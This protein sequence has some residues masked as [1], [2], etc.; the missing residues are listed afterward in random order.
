MEVQTV[1]VACLAEGEEWSAKVLG[2]FTT[3]DAAERECEK[4]CYGYTYVDDQVVQTG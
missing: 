4:H 3:K 2:V 1:F